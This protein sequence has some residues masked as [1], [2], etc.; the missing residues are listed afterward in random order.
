MFLFTFTK[1]GHP[2]LVFFLVKN[3]SLIC[4]STSDEVHACLWAAQLGPKRDKTPIP[5][6]TWAGPHAGSED[7][8][9]SS[10]ILKYS[11]CVIFIYDLNKCFF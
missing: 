5:A 7:P 9:P 8:G 6:L 4:K 10:E 11:V 1:I 3:C 2:G